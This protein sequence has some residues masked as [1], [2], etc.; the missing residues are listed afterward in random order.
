M[1]GRPPIGAR[2]K[3]AREARR[4]T[5]ADVAEAAGLTKGFLS[6]LERDRAN[7]SVAALLRVC[8]SLGLAPGSLFEAVPVGEVVR[9]G[10]YPAIEFGGAG[11]REYLLT[12]PGERR[13]QAILGE[14]DAGGGSGGETYAL[15][16]D[17]EFVFV[18]DG[19]LEITVDGQ[20]TRLGGGDAFTFAPSRQ[21]S[22]R[23]TAATRVLWVI[24]PALPADGRAT[25]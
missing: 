18:L 6:K 8:E 22:F 17:V 2:L 4:R 11:M 9:R 23:A 24:S 10:A 15:P 19:R 12:P 7:A 16:A 25:G 3:A 14:L 13:V 5:L 21:H 20:V 1:D